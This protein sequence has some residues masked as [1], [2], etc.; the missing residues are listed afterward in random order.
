MSTLKLIGFSGEVPR[1]QSRM[2]PDS[3]A[4]LAENVRLQNGALV[5][6]R[7]PRF[8]TAISTIP[9]GA[10]KTI[11]KNGSEWLAWDKVVNAAPGPVAADRLYF[12]G[13]GKPKM[14]VAGVNYDLAV[15]FPANPLTATLSGTPTG[16][17]I[18]T[19]IYVYTYV[20]DFGEESEPTAISNEVDWVDGNTVTLS[21]F[22]A[23][24]AGRNITKQRIYRLQGSASNGADLY[25]IDER[26]ASTANY[27]DS[28]PVDGFGESL[29]SRNWN[30]P[31]DDLQGLIS[32]PNGMMV[33]FKGKDL[34]FCE[35]F[36]PHAWPEA[37]VLTTDYNIVALGAYATTVVVATEGV[38]YIVAGTAP[39]NMV[40]EKVELN[41]PCIN[42]RGM[43]DLGYSVAYPSHDGLVVVD[44]SGANVTSNTL[45]TR[46]DWQKVS[47]GSFVAGQYAGRYF[48]SYEYLDVKGNAQ[49]GTFIIDLTGATPFLI[50]AS[51]RAEAC[52]YDLP[53]GVLYMLLGQDIYEWD[54][55][56]QINDTMSWT[57]KR[58]VLPFP[59]NFGAIM[60][61]G[62]DD[63]SD[64]EQAAIDAMNEAIRIAN[65]IAF[66]QPSIGGEVNGAALNSYPINGDM[67]GK[68]IPPKFIS[69]Q[70]Y[71]QKPDSTV[72][73]LV[74]TISKLN[75]AC[76][77][78]AGFESRIWE[79]RVNGTAEVSQI[80][81]ARMMT[82]LKGV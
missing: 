75:K 15:P 33:A 76:R 61:E 23:P 54:A 6:I 50:R 71:A 29:P 46:E 12:T 43:V 35:P 81:M 80:S 82:E 63:V 9:S 4:Q 21:G 16:T 78:K 70:I 60:V 57:S 74:G 20:T 59:T 55:Q 69:V 66:A 22:L 7:R 65:A 77:I 13:D 37:Y 47:P 68:P 38:P 44:S 49:S 24:P 52:F 73:M 5:P 18:T 41:L 19:R 11:Y 2:L 51:Q 14:R 27:V 1:I 67:L 36:H 26:A 42:P 34:Y 45:M 58:F 62:S 17:Q 8:E 25:F 32:L 10:I 53:R 72:M 30:A 3:A 31:P 64:D 39:E 56:G 79:I 48:A 40:M 28:I